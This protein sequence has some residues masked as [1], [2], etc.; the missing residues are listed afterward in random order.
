MDAEDIF[1]GLTSSS[2]TV[3]Y[4]P[5][6]LTLRAEGNATVMAASGEFHGARVA[7]FVACAE[8]ALRTAPDLI[9][10]L[11]AVSFIDLAALAS[12]ESLERTT[13]GLGGSLRIRAP[14][15]Q[16]RRLFGLARVEL[17]MTE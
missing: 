4:G 10:D 2:T 7:E 16:V 17:P 15:S 14:S 1:A 9:L 6:T 8:A 5:L 13:S 3:D 11:R 12:I